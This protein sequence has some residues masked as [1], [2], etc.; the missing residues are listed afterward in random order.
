VGATLAEL[1]TVAD[2]RFGSGTP[3]TWYAGLGLITAIPNPDGSG[4]VEP[5]GGGYARPA[6]TNNATNFPAAVVEAGRVIKVNGTL[7]SW[8]DPTS[9][10]GTAG[11][12]G[13]FTAA[14]GGTPRWWFEMDGQMPIRTSTTIVELPAGDLIMPFLTS[15]G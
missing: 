8:G 3:A 6:V 11:Y 13:F 2:Q 7:I 5:S 4:F 10:W 14:T 12:V 1:L 9:N 15:D